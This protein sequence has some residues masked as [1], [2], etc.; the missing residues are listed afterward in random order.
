[1][2]GTPYPLSCIPQ[3]SSLRYLATCWGAIP[4]NRML[5]SADELFYFL[6]FAMFNLSKCFI[7]AKYSEENKCERLSCSGPA[8]P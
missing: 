7:Y 6:V 2:R 3:F 8:L 1:M 4:F 5:G